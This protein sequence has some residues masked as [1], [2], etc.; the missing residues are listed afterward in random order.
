[1]TIVSPIDFGD[2][3]ARLPSWHRIFCTIKIRSSQSDHLPKNKDLLI[4]F[5]PVRC[6][7]ILSQ[8]NFA[9]TRRGMPYVRFLSWHHFT[10]TQ[11]GMPHLRTFLQLHRHSMR[12]VT[13]GFCLGMTS[14]VHK[15]GCHL[16]GFC[17]SYT[18]YYTIA[19]ISI[20]L[21]NENEERHISEF[22]DI[23]SILIAIVAEWSKLDWKGRH[24]SEYIRSILI[25]TKLD[26]TELKWKG[27]F[28]F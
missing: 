10:C 2:T 4:N 1:M 20:D 21:A 6:H 9:G 27:N 11:K 28:T 18:R 19:A 14:Q 23:G 5:M 17:F 24:I 26:R 15:E 16:S 3:W 7:M 13:Y 8:N 22:S 25:A 12:I